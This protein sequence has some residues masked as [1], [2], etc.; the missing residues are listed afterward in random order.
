[1]KKTLILQCPGMVC[2]PPVASKCLGEAHRRL[3]IIYI[4][5]ITL[6][7]ITLHYI[8]S[9]FFL[10]TVGNFDG[11]ELARM[12]DNLPFGSRFCSFVLSDNRKDAFLLCIRVRNK[13]ASPN[14]SCT[15]N[16]I[17]TL[18]FDPPLPPSL[19]VKKLNVTTYQE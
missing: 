14:D 3:D 6:H 7:Y 17:V 15:L 11:Y 4:I 8:N 2:S 16:V 1:M 18:R 5:Y 9:F 12:L 10:H 13:G 19:S